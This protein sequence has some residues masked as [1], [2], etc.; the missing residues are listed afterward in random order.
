M[1]RTRPL[2]LILLG[3]AAVGAVATAV[4]PAVQDRLDRP[5]REQAL[6]VAH[7]LSAPAGASDSTACH[8]EGMVACWETPTAVQDV[9]R[10]LAASMGDQ[11]QAA[12]TSTCEAVPVTTGTTSEATSDS[13]FVRVRFKT[14]G[15][16]AFVDP[17]V[18]RDA[19]TGADTVVGSLVSL[20]AN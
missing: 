12:V 13:C 15:T 19:D 17:L 8:G 6:S 14:H 16:F 20:S 11:T 9:A 1:A 5:A 18:E 2:P 7:A 10:A 3:L 4:S